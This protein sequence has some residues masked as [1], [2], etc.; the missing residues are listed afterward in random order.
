M[1]FIWIVYSHVCVDV[2]RGSFL[3]LGVKIKKK[4]ARTNGM[5]FLNA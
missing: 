2:Y 1:F 5:L 4:R 3:M